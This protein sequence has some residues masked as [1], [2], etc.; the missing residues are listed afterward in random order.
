MYSYMSM[1]K[2]LKNGV[3]RFFRD[4]GGPTATEYAVLLVLVVFGCLSA[5][6]LLGA[7]LSKSVQSTAEALPGGEGGTGG[8]G[9]DPGQDKPKEKP[10]KPSQRRRTRRPSASNLRGIAKPQ[11]YF[12]LAAPAYPKGGHRRPYTGRV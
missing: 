9:S 5:I 11:G 10:K 12:V 8:G 1:G 6:S 4:C 2:R 3:R 7:F